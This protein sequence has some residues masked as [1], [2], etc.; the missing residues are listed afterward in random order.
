VPFRYDAKS[1]WYHVTYEDDDDE[2]MTRE[3]LI[4]VLVEDTD[5]RNR[6]EAAPPPTRLR[7]AQKRRPLASKRAPSDDVANGT[8][9][10]ENA[11]R[12]TRRCSRLASQQSAASVDAEEADGD[13][14]DDEEEDDGVEEQPSRPKRKRHAPSNGALVSKRERPKRSG[15]QRHTTSAD[16]SSQD[17]DEYVDD[18]SPRTKHG[19]HAPS[20]RSLMV[21]STGARLS[22]RPTRLASQKSAAS[23]DADS[24]GGENDEEAEVPP[25]WPKRG[26][27]VSQSARTDGDAK[28]KPLKRS[29][30]QRCA[31]S[32]DADDIRDEP[33]IDGT[34]PRRRALLAGAG[35][36][37][38]DSQPGEDGEVAA[39]ATPKPRGC[40]AM[41]ES[42][43]FR[44]FQT[45]LAPDVQARCVTRCGR[46]HVRRD[47]PTFALCTSVAEPTVGTK[48][49]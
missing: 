46:S 33:E 39:A 1:G 44:I 43:S 45:N 48:Q 8:M 30:M 28:S 23:V 4:D 29:G 26:A 38:G 14:G 37:K 15:F 19:R 5:T 24:D 20:R 32:A 41:S 2:E 12:P 36:S 21:G 31:G 40:K 10:A 17:E 6:S 35:S 49:C 3:E 7:H 27:P 16:S 22:T 25:S 9:R 47:S 13:D 42:V 11:V 34:S 18:N